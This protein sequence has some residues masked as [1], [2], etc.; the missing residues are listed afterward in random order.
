MTSQSGPSVRWNPFGDCIESAAHNSHHRRHHQ[1]WT[2]EKLRAPRKSE[3]NWT[4]DYFRGARK[5]RKKEDIRK[6]ARMFI[7]MVA[8]AAD[9]NDCCE[10]RGGPGPG[11]RSQGKSLGSLPLRLALAV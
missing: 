4:F 1:N 3:K 9:C 11:P 6:F 7:V 2:F 8:P 5:S 10:F